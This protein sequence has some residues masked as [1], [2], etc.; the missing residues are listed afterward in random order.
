VAVVFEHNPYNPLTVHAVKTCPFDANAVLIPA[1]ALLQ[2][3][4]QAGFSTLVRR[5]RLF[6]PGP[7]R[8]LR[9]LERRLAWLPLGAQYYVAARKG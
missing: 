9:H 1:R 5:Y 6:F 8:A 4:K 3:M 2:H 7:L